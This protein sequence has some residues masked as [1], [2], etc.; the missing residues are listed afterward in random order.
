[1][2]QH[3]DTMTILVKTLLIM[4]LLL[5]LINEALPN[6]RIYFLLILLINDFSYKK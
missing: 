2:E 6:N 1:M 5:T 4:T 3:V